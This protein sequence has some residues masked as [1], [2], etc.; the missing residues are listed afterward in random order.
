MKEL[1]AYNLVPL[2]G[3]I[4]MLL[5]I[6]Q[7]PGLT[8][9]KRFFF[10]V[11]IGVFLMELLFRNADY[12][13]SG[14]ETYTARRA[15]YS[16]IGYCTRPLIVYSLIATDLNLRDGLTRK[17]F[18]L[19]GIPLFI[20]ALGAFSVFFTDKV[21]YFR[22]PNNFVGGPLYWL[23]N[24]AL[25]SYFLVLAI[26]AVRDFKV[27]HIT[28]AGMIISAL[29]LMVIAVVAELFDFHPFLCESIIV[30]AL[31][32]YML[33]FQNEENMDEQKRLSHEAMIDGLTG[34]YNRAAYNK[35]EQTYAGIK[36]AKIGL[37]VL[38]VDRFKMINDTYGHDMGDEVL[39]RVANILTVTFR[40][41][42]YVIRYG[43]DEFV[44]VITDLSDDLAYVVERKVESINTL[45]E[46]TISEM[47]K[48]SVS[49][50]LAFSDNGLTKE[51]FKNADAALY[52][53]KSTTRRNCTIYRAEP[54]GNKPAD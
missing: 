38:D 29:I 43:G 33:F 44:V 21:Y 25:I 16:A 42:D 22:E 14:Y 10:S 31:L 47:P 48:T 1:I 50:G 41:T 30:L 53:T 46:N 26:M 23:N 9:Y 17:K 20:T 27:G 7:N 28:H 4:I 39:K 3:S 18:L 45:L 19:L 11:T 34:L 40:A 12:I 8:R 54:E 37:L 13:T 36:N 49:A 51:L 32:E 6:V 15:L 2:L 5:F 35:L 52:H 24:V